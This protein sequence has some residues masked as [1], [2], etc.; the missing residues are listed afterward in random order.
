MPWQSGPEPL[1]ISGQRFNKLLVL[2]FVG[3]AGKR[4][5]FL[6]RCDCGVETVGRIDQ[7]MS[8]HKKSCG[9]DRTGKGAGIR[10]GNY[11]HGMRKS[12]EYGSWLSMRRRCADTTHPKYCDYGGRGIYVCE[13]WEG[14][15]PNFISDMGPK[16]SKMHSLERL[17][18]DGP[19]SPENCK[20]ATRKEQANNRRISR[21]APIRECETCG[22]EFQPVRNDARFCGV[23]CRMIARK[24]RLDL[25]NG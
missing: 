17:D 9:C 24:A 11:K 19:Y 4:R 25:I 23:K 2:R 10:N 20:W 5:Y 21:R 12:A 8:G 18:N 22:E 15:F 1:D 6:C 13:R 7:I 14:S 3:K 16:P